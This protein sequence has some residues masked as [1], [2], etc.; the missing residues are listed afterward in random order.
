M[1]FSNETKIKI[2]LT[3]IA[4]GAIMAFQT[5][6]WAWGGRGHHVVCQAATALV[7]EKGLKEFLAKRPHTMG[8]LCNVPDIYWKSLGS[9]ANKV[10]NPTHYVD[11]EILGMTAATVPLDFAELVQKYQGSDNLFEKG[12]KVFSVAGEFGSNW[13]RA[14]QFF[15]RAT[16]N[17]EQWAQ[18][19]PPK[20]R[21][22]EQAEDFLF[23]KL[24]YDFMLNLGLMGHF[25][26]DNAQPFHVTADYDGWAAGHG[27]IHSYYEDD[28]VVSLPYTLEKMVVEKGKTL[29]KQKPQ[30]LTAPK[31]LEKMKALGVLSFNDMK[32]VLTLD[33][34]LEKS[35]LKE[36]KGMKIKTVAKR[37]PA[38]EVAKKFEPLVVTHMARAAALLARLWDE[39][40]VQVGRPPLSEY[41]SFKYPFTPDFVAPDYLPEEKK[42]N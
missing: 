9:E 42:K 37:K 13:W 28:V 22:Q 14:D 15:R 23:N 36:E 17:K 20:E 26:G 31:T 34:V 25:V 29:Q 11:P 1:K 16:A 30:F 40:Y 38:S 39:A 24:S 27:G 4:V 19:T 5:R 33:P 6:A 7:Q 18:A 21:N 35:V 10:G 2:V 41:K 8:H 12:K 32:A 3:L